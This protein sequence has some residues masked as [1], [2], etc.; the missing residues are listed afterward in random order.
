MNVEEKVFAVLSAAAGV[1]AL[2][3][4]SRIKPPGVQ[5][6]LTLPYIVHFPV[7][8]QTSQTHDTGLVNLKYW[9]YQ[10]SCFG[11]SYSAAKALAAQ[12]VVALGNYRG[13]GN[14]S[15]HYSSE[16]TMP[17]EEDVRVQQVVLEFEIWE[18]L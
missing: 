6:G 3:P 1:T 16:R 14:I 9:L 17:Y 13:P 7:G 8:A 5:Q 18:S 12:V 11:A 2:V 4:G 15:S 10:V